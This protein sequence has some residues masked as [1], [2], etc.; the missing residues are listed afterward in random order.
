MKPHYKSRLSDVKEGTSRFAVDDSK[1]VRPGLCSCK[2]RIQ[3]VPFSMALA[4]S[5]PDRLKPCLNRS[6]RACPHQLG[7]LA[8]QKMIR[9]S[10][11]VVAH[12][13]IL[14]AMLSKLS[15]SF[16]HCF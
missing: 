13:S 6:Y 2:D 9:H 16:G 7:V 3:P 11:D 15:V 1:Q 10:S 8:K 14:G 4:Q 5:E 12:D